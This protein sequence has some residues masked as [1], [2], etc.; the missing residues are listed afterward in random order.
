M[1]NFAATRAAVILFALLLGGCANMSPRVAQM[2]SR[3]SQ[4]LGATVPFC[5]VVAANG[6]P[7]MW[8]KLDTRPTKEQINRFNSIWRRCPQYKAAVKANPAAAVPKMQAKVPQQ[9]LKPVQLPQP[10]PPQAVTLPAP[11]TEPPAVSATDLTPPK[12][13]V[14]HLKIPPMP[15]IPPVTKPAPTPEPW[16]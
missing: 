3:S 7:I 13:L 8:S 4:P 6:G 12:P 9:P 16:K 2:I 11:S 15:S 14:R 5:E 10:I 1:M